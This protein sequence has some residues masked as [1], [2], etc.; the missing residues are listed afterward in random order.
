MKNINEANIKKLEEEFTPKYIKGLLLN[1]LHDVGIPEVN[2]QVKLYNFEQNEKNKKEDVLGWY[3][4]LS[5]FRSVPIMYYNITSI[6][7]ALEEYSLI[8]K[9][10]DYES[11]RVYVKDS[12]MDT[13]CHEY[14]HVI[15]EFLH[16]NK[17]RVVS[18]SDKNDNLKIETEVEFK[19]FYNNFLPRNGFPANEVFAEDFGIH[20]ASKIPFEECEGLIDMV[21]YYK[22]N[23]FNE[24]ALKWISQPKHIR[25]LDTIF[26]EDKW[27]DKFY[28]EGMAYLGASKD[29]CERFIKVVNKKNPEANLTLVKCSEPIDLNLLGCDEVKFPLYSHY[30]VKI[31]DEKNGVSY[32][33]FASEHSFGKTY[34]SKDDINSLWTKVKEIEPEV[35]KVK[36]KKVKI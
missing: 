26:Q 10:E 13:I 36:S 20:L 12:I 29:I 19:K 28:F 24:S 7:K 5:Q 18:S 33:D 35:K 16:F 31:N 17:N 32:L 6:V 3:K 11:L 1:L 30:V 22:R 4:S 8:D 21:E 15:E 2:I 34:L 25:D 23:L 9:D 14:G 27:M